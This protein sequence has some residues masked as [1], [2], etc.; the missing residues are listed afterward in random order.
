M[1]G[2]TAQGTKASFKGVSFTVTG[3]S[4]NPP[5]EQLVGMTSAYDLVGANVMVPTGEKTPG[6]MTIDFIADNTF[7]NPQV[8]IGQHGSLAISGPYSISR[9]VVCTDGGVQATVGDIIKGTLEFTITDYY[10]T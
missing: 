5:A 9:N 1:A 6:T 8:I 3:F 2:S 10:G 7:S 4:F